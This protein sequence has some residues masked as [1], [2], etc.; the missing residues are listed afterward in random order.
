MSRARE[1]TLRAVRQNGRESDG[2]H[3]TESPS[4]LGTA[5]SS[6]ETPHLRSDQVLEALEC[7]HGEGVI[8]GQ[9]DPA[10]LMWF[11]T[12]FSWKLISLTK[13]SY[14]GA[15]AALPTESR[16]ASP[17]AIRSAADGTRV[18][19]EPSVDMWSFGVLAFEVLTCTSPSIRRTLSR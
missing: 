9:V 16:Y 4:P 8:H 10:H 15:F 13:A 19:L 5:L 14:V 17:E 6:A 11:A 12:D 3:R 2:G 1:R 18:R 7:V